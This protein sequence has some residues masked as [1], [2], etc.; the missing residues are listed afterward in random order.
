MRK[1]TLCLAAALAA[2]AQQ[3]QQLN[4][5]DAHGDAPYLIEDGW[6]PLLNG[7]DLSGWH[8]QRYRAERMAHHPASCGTACWGLR[9]FPRV[10]GPG[11]RILNGPHGRTANLVSDQKFGDIELY[12]EFMLAKGSNSGVYLHS[13][14]EVPDLR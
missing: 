7:R 5:G 4:D 2:F 13:L 12:V 10:P 14:Y 9:A 11:D 3:R 6:T 1:W 8:G